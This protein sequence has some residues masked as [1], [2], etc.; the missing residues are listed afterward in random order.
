MDI[1]VWLR[2][3][4]LAKYEA[5]FRENEIDETVLPSLTHEN[6]KEL[7]VASVGQR[8]KLLNPLYG[9]ALLL[10]QQMPSHVPSGLSVPQH[11]WVLKHRRGGGG[12]P[13]PPPPPPPPSWHFPRQITVAAV[14]P[15]AQIGPK[16]GPKNAHPVRHARSA[17]PHAASQAVAAGT[18]FEAIVPRLYPRYNFVDL[19]NDASALN[20]GKVISSSYRRASGPRTAKA[21]RTGTAISLSHPRAQRISR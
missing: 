20:P 4:G 14:H 2:S 21:L 9:H 13:L 6:L 3:L 11:F 5:I 7:G 17:T 16:I 8:V 10:G 15:T 12:G 1:V 19:Y 18:I